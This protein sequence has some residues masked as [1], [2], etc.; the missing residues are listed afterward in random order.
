MTTH[1][2]KDNNRLIAVVGITRLERPLRPAMRLWHGAGFW[3]LIKRFSGSHRQDEPYTPQEAVAPLLL[4]GVHA[5]NKRRVELP[6]LNCQALE[7]LRDIFQTLR[8]HARVIS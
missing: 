3:A 2:L 6:V 1:N 5:P 7:S 8:V 4:T